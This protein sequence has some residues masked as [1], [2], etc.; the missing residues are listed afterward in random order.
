MTIA[1]AGTV[2]DA[3]AAR[4]GPGRPRDEEIDGQII[5]ATLALIDAEA[6]V[7]VS[8]I[9]ERSGV[10]RAALYRRWPALTTLVAAALDVGRTVPPAVDAEGDL[11]AAVMGAVFGDS[12][13]A[14]ASGYSEV[15]FRHRIRLVMADRAL[16]KAYWR[17]HVSRRRVP[18]EA[19]LRRGIERGILRADLDVEA[20]FDAMAG[21]AYYQLV[22]RGDRF[23]EPESQA[24]MKAALDVIWCG[25]LA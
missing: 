16:Q 17:S 13:A 24:R 12:A 19:A 21:V 4:R 6:E 8:R 20:C 14:T 10:S 15:R 1:D 2:A 3:G 5:A 11:Q 23:E 18:V 25:M 9:V 22:V 7:T